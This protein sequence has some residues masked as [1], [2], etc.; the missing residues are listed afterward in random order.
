MD[1]HILLDPVIN[2][3]KCPKRGFKNMIFLLT[4]LPKGG[5]L[6]RSTKTQLKNLKFGMVVN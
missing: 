6:I 4:F 3:W 1:L 5:G 2:S